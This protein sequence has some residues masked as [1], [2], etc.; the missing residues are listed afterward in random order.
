MDIFYDLWRSLSAKVDENN[1]SRGEG[2]GT[3]DNWPIVLLRQPHQE[4]IAGVMPAKV[5]AAVML[6]NMHYQIC[7]GGWEQWH[8]NRYSYAAPALLQLLDGA[9]ALGIEHAADVAGMMRIFL[10][11]L[12][13]VD[14]EFDEDDGNRGRRDGDLCERYYDLDGEKLCQDILDRFEDCALQNFGA[15][16]FRKRG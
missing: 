10:Q 14:H 12:N 16:S 5:N 9:A 11:R 13:G 8:G 3:A 15:A 1:A 6:G 7:N 4:E 2:I